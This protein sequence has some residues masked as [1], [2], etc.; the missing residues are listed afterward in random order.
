MTKLTSKLPFELRRLR[1]KWFV[2][3]QENSNRVAQFDDFVKFVRSEAKEMNS[4]YGRRLFTTLES[5]TS[6]DRLRSKTYHFAIGAAHLKKELLL[7]L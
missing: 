4:L 1:V 2:S 3:I 5:R 6:S 7:V